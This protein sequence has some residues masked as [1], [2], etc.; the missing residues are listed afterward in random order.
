MASANPREELKILYDTLMPVLARATI[1]DFNSDLRTDPKNS[2]KT[3]EILVGVH[4]LLETIREKIAELEAAN[5]QLSD[6]RDRSVSLLD[7][8][9]RKSLER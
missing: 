3:N 1:G 6:A 2:K 4:V 5:L 9:L 8:V 7:D